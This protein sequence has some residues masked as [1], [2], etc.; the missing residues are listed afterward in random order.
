MPRSRIQMVPFALA[1]MAA[2]PLSAGSAA[3][4]D[5]GDGQ[6]GDGHRTE[7]HRLMAAAP[8]DAAAALSAVRAAGYT[9]VRELEWHDGGWKIKAR[10]AQGHKA[11]LRVDATSAAVTRHGS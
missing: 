1:L 10:D 8:I 5:D 2:L 11:K 9:E 7:Q 4:A 6:R 3:A